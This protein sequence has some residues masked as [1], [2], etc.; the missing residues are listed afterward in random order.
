MNA[1][2]MQ[3]EQQK[4]EKGISGIIWKELGNMDMQASH[5]HSQ[6]GSRNVPKAEDSRALEPQIRGSRGC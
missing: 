5:Q 4:K 1:D 6:V 3:R 2:S